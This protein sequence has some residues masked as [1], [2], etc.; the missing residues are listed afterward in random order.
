MSLHESGHPI[1]YTPKFWL[2][3]LEIQLLEMKL[4]MKNNNFD[5]AVKEACDLISVAEDMVRLYF[6]KD[7]VFELNKRLVEN[8]PKWQDKDR[9][10]MEYQ[11]EKFRKLKEELGE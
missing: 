11:E 9:G 10:T 5:H 7:V 6:N 8:L 4:D 3:L 1:Y 2:D